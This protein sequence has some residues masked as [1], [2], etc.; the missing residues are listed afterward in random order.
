MSNET[1]WTEDEAAAKG[2]RS[3]INGGKHSFA[4]GPTY[5]QPDSNSWIEP[6]NQ[7]D[8]A[9]TVGQHDMSNETSWTEDDAAAKGYRSPINGGKHSFAQS[10]LVPL[11][12][13]DDGKDDAT[14]HPYRKNAYN[15]N[16][17]DASNEAQWATDAPAGYR[18]P[19]TG[20]HSMAG[21]NFPQVGQLSMSEA[22]H[23]Y[24][25]VE[26]NSTLLPYIVRDH[27]WSN[28]QEG[29]VNFYRYRDDAPPGYS[30][31][32]TYDKP[33]PTNIPRQPKVIEED[34]DEDED[35]GSDGKNGTASAGKGDSKKD[36][37]K[38]GD[39][40]DDKKT[41]AKD[42][43]KDK[44]DGKKDDAKK[45]DKAD[46]KKDDAKK[47]AKSDDK[48][49]SDKKDGAKADDKTRSDKKD[50][51]KKDDKAKDSGKN[52][53]KSDNKTAQ[54]NKK[55]QV[56]SAPTPIKPT[57]AAKAQVVNSTKPSSAS[58]TTT[59]KV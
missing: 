28:E 21:Q 3:P 43:K 18:Q 49:K 17:Y 39:K 30:D 14:I 44:A 42:D 36:D 15:D 29:F 4:Q 27:A 55:A 35:A 53:T 47:D 45:D 38:S 32:V 12:K 52:A 51:G 54:A 1:S 33:H 34:D 8:H 19:I 46:G 40:K 5:I 37:K 9:W 26:T 59:T 11:K 13:L 2:Y 24:F 7:R 25:R 23:K 22:L 50:D 16:Q 31:T 10:E 58:N 56:V 57:Q 6:Y 41:D 48:T 20:K